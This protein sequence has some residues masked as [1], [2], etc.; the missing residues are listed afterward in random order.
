MNFIKKTSLVSVTV[1]AAAVM[2]IG[3]AYAAKDREF[4]L[5]VTATVTLKIQSAEEAADI[6]NDGK[7]DA[8]D[9]AIVARN[10]S[11][12]PVLDGRADVDKNGKVDVFDLG[13]V[14][15]HFDPARVNTAEP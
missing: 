10:I 7:V 13:F 8:A 15:L 4:D 6:N 3:L 12:S 14:A 1:V 2:A 5:P 9:L 11:S